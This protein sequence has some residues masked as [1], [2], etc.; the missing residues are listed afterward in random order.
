MNLYEQ[1]AHN[2]R[3]TWL[4]VFIFVIF[5]GLLGLGFDVFMLRMRLPVAVSGQRADSYD[6]LENGGEYE[7]PLRRPAHSV[8]YATILALAGGFAMT[9]NSAFNGKSMVLKSA[10]AR[11]PDP[12]KPEEKQFLNVLSEM[13][14][15]A[16][17]P[18][19]EGYILPDADLN[20]FATGLNPANS[21]VAV[22][23]GVLK[24]LSREE[25][26]GVVAHEMS[27]IRN[28]D[29]R[30]MT[31][32]AALVG[33]TALLSDFLGRMYWRRG[34]RSSGSSDRGG[35]GAIALLGF[36]V[37]LV[38]MILA[39]LVSQIMAMAISRK[40]EYM[41]DASGAE[42]T[43][44]PLSLA[45]AL[46]KIRNAVNPTKCINNGVAHLCITDP[47]G[48]LMEDK[49]GLAADLFAS[50]P[51]LEKRILALKMM[52]YGVTTKEDRIQKSEFR[53]S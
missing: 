41:A 40:R 28:Y 50:H 51:P 38:L 14:A 37:W 19:P 35:G 20:A 8:P 5:V 10:M 22:T 6:E 4:I 23:E 39:P 53:M 44:N 9:L 12:L 24:S 49:T 15:A 16:G 18:V 26:Q 11:K 7:I 48:S 47:R 42:L 2:R 36:A 32:I 33:A 3:L 43:R 17:L 45:S 27:H 31:V 1:Q 30:L 21:A 34:G 46:E 29:M 25:L 13:S 52:G